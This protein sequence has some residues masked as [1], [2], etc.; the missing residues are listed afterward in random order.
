[1]P[2]AQDPAAAAEASADT[3]MGEAAPCVNTKV[4]SSTYLAMG[5]ANVRAGTRVL[6]LVLVQGGLTK[7]LAE[8]TNTKGY[9]STYLAMGFANVRAGTRVLMLV[10]VLVQ[11]NV[12]G[13]RRVKDHHH[14]ALTAPCT[15]VTLGKS[16]RC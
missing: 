11:A 2:E 3:P 10:L 5:F 7:V 13:A 12:V 8:G 6:T 15:S 9:S 16:K 4:Y 1:M 14:G